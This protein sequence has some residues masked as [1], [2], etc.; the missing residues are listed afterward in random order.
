MNLD[1]AEALLGE[2][3]D[4]LPLEDFFNA[5][6]RAPLAL[7][8]GPTHPRARLFG[9]DP[10]RTLLD[11]FATHASGLDCHSPDPSG[12]PPAA[13]PV[14]NAAAFRDL[15]ADYHALG[16]TVRV[17]DVVPLSPSLA[18]FVRA[19][20]YLLHQ[21][22]DASVFW[23]KAGAGAIVHYDNRDNL[24]VQLQG[25]KRWYVSTDP[26]GLQNNWKHVEESLPQLPRHRVVDVEPGDL[27]YIPRGTPHTVE[28]TSESLHLA[29]LFVP[30]TLREV[31]IAMIDQLAD[32]DRSFRETMIARVPEDGADR[33]T[34]QI[35]AAAGRLAAQVRSASFVREAM[36]HRSA[37]VISDLPALPRPDG[38]PPLAADTRIRHTA[39]AVA[40]LRPIPDRIDFSIP[41]GRVVVHPG[42]EQE[43]RFIAR[44]PR[45]RIGDI[46]GESSVEVR[47]ALVG[48]LIATG[49]LEPDAGE[50]EAG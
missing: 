40:H 38:A 17:P 2:V 47:I 29:I 39:L 23:S 27:L 33:L 4:P 25:R 18:R 28:S 10:A 22:V 16:Y 37:R 34:P 44:T 13:R 46:P 9:D 12:A 41:G 35:A 49:Y 45:F 48:R 31:L 8:G 3:I 20:E 24:V 5:L 26:P 43:L 7:K 19:L 21:P 50:G 42:V 15:I 14:A 30:T 36:E 1:Q 6:G 11:A 32:L